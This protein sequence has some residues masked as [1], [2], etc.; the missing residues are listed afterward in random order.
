MRMSTD[1]A[2]WKT[3]LRKLA[4]K[5]AVK[6]IAAL[7]GWN[8]CSSMM[9]LWARGASWLSGFGL[10]IKTRIGKVRWTWSHQALQRSA[11]HNSVMSSNSTWRGAWHVAY[12]PWWMYHTLTNIVRP[13]SRKRT[14]A[15]SSKMD[16]SSRCQMGRGLW[17]GAWGMGFGISC[18]IA[19]GSCC[20]SSLHFR[21]CG[22]TRRV[23]LGP[24]VS[25][26]KIWTGWIG[27]TSL[28][29]HM[30]CPMGWRR[31]L[32]CLK[33]L[34]APSLES[35]PQFDWPDVHHLLHRTCQGAPSAMVPWSSCGYGV[36]G[37]VVDWTGRECA[38]QG[39]DHC[40]TVQTRPACVNWS[41]KWNGV[42]L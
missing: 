20:C 19:G 10:T 29:G 2:F 24:E 33:R 21:S 3:P 5:M 8:P 34:Q 42:L 30:K 14:V 23:H 7:S 35:S 9:C 27:C 18:I 15:S 17:L 12:R 6:T 39:L 38:D 26:W 37:L 4:K 40:G 13:V 32:A 31:H 16:W 1:S 36:L 22:D 41:H 28:G 11:Y 25:G